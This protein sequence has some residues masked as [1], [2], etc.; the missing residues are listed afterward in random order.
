MLHTLLIFEKRSMRILVRKN[1]ISHRKRNKLT[2]VIYSVTLGA[3]IFLITSATLTLKS[4][5]MQGTFDQADIYIHGGHLNTDDTSID[6]LLF[7]DS[8]DSVLEKYKDKIKSFAYLSP[9]LNGMQKTDSATFKFSSI[10][11]IANG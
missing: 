2:S 5:N 8:T 4:I 11:R 10:S 7:A 9:N 6:Q 1:L 3:V